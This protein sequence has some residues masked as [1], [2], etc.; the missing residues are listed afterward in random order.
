MRLGIAYLVLSASRPAGC[1][2][3]SLSILVD[4]AH[5][6]GIHRTY[7][8]PTGITNLLEDYQTSLLSTVFD[9][10][11]L[12]RVKSVGKSQ[13]AKYV[14]QLRSNIALLRQVL[15]AGLGNPEDDQYAEQWTLLEDRLRE[16][17]S[18]Q[19]IHPCIWLSLQS[20][21]LAEDGPVGDRKSRDTF[22]RTQNLLAPLLA[23]SRASLLQQASDLPTSLLLPFGIPPSATASEGML[24][25]AKPGPR[26]A[27]LPVNATAA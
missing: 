21:Q 26:L 12:E 1:V 25:L 7:A 16:V 6:L 9:D 11:L 8:I 14:Q 2:L 4:A 19:T 22:L 23:S 3:D 18:N 20:R 15:A 27:L 17:R 13:R 5:Q 10:G 24:D